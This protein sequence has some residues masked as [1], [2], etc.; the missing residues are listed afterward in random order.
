MLMTLL[1]AEVET[2]M[3][4]KHHTKLSQY[5]N[6]DG[7]IL[8]RTPHLM[9]V[10]RRLIPRT[11]PTWAKPQQQKKYICST[12]KPRELGAASPRSRYES[13]AADSNA[14]EKEKE[15]E[16]AKREVSS[17]PKMKFMRT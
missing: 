7:P 2:P 6:K 17:G 8:T 9:T 14:I 4:R 1:E 16:R 3:P 12:E 15:K 10:W 13:F 11:S 5:T